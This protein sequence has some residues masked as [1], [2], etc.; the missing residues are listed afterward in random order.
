MSGQI[1]HDDEVPAFE[2]RSR[3]LFEMVDENQP[4]PALTSDAGGGFDGRHHP[5]RV[6]H[7]LFSIPTSASVRCLLS[8]L[9]GGWHAFLMVILCHRKN[10]LIA[11][12]IP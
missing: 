12:R 9:F 10:R 1:I 3:T 6:K 11:V 5:C 8:V 4:I 7:A 2:L